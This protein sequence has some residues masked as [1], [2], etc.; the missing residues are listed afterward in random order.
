MLDCG[1]T[2]QTVLNFLPLP[3]VQS[4]KLSNMPNWIP[5]RD[6]D[7]QMDGELKEC[8]GRVFIDSAPEFCPPMDKLVDF[9][10]IDVILISNYLNMLALPYITE[11]T[12]FKGKVY[13]TEPTRQI[14]QFFLEE[15]VDYIEV[16]PKAN[17]AS[18]WKQMLHILPSPLSEAFRPKKWK[19]IFS[20]KDIQR[21]LA[22]VTITGYD[23][24]LVRMSKT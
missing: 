9:S 12:G 11:R 14:G 18:L 13:A 10:E 19:Q 20:I 1:L 22:R 16:A 17:N 24:K 3:F 5:N 4:S 8:C 23:E 7:T 6:H 21:S 15:L 2:E